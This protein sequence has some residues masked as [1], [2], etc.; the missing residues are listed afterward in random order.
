MGVGSHPKGVA[1]NLLNG[2][3]YVA[4]SD[5]G[6]TPSTISVI[7]RMGPLIWPYKDSKMAILHIQQ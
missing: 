4:N 7:L 3:V 5:D 6:R 1:V 2:F